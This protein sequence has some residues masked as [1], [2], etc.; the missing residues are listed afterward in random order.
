MSLCAVSWL[1]YSVWEFG[2]LTLPEF[3]LPLPRKTLVTYPA[4]LLVSPRLLQ[5]PPRLLC[6]FYP[7]AR[8]RVIG[9]LVSIT[10]LQHK[11]DTAHS[12]AMHTG[13]VSLSPNGSQR[14]L[15]L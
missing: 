13:P 3:S 8:C 10:C 6:H 15:G 1:F 4:R 9:P 11:N 12:S 7:L 2:S 5:F 14:H